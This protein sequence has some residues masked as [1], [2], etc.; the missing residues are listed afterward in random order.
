MSGVVVKWHYIVVQRIFI[1]LCYCCIFVIL[2]YS[3]SCVTGVLSVVT[4]DCPSITVWY[5]NLSRS[6]EE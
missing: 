1:G 3:W 4:E 5:S 6:C 2:L